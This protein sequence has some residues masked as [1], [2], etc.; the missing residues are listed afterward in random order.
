MTRSMFKRLQKVLIEPPDF[1]QDITVRHNSRLLNL[2]LLIMIIVFLGVDGY[3]FSTIPG[4]MPPWYGYVF[5]LGSFSLNRGGYY[6]FSALL[7]LAMFP[8]VIFANITSGESASPITTIYFLIPGLILAGIL[9]TFQF[10]A[11]FALTELLLVGSMPILAPAVIPNFE[12][13]VGPL[14]ALT[15]SGALVLVAIFHRDRMEADRQK[16]LQKSEEDY[17]AI[18]ENAIFGIYQSS[19]EGKFLRANSALARIYGYDSQQDLLDSVTSIAEQVYVDPSDRD[20]FRHGLVTDEFVS[21]FVARNRRKDGSLIWISSNARAV[22]NA[23]GKIIYFE[24]TVEDITEKKVM[25]QERQMSEERYRLISSVISDYVFSSRQTDKGEVQLEWVTGAFEQITGYAAEELSAPSSW[26]S[27]VHPDDLAQDSRDM[28]ALLHNQR[29]VSELRIIHKDGSIRWVRSYAHPIW[30]SNA[31]KLIGIYGAVQDIT[32]QKRFEQEREDLIRELE[33]KNA[34]LE[35]FTYTVSHDLKAPLITIRGF[36]GFLSQD[37][38]SGNVER[39]EGDLKRISAATDKMQNLLNDLLELSR[40]GRMMNDP[41][42][43]SLEQLAVDASELLHGRLKERGAELEVKSPLPKVFGDQQR[44]LEV[45]QN[46]ID[47]AAKF[48]IGQERPRVEIGQSASEREGFATLYVRDNGIG[49]APQFHER[50]FGLFNRLNPSIEGTGVGLPLVK[51]IVEF[52]GGRIWVESAEGKGA[53]FF[54]TLP[55]PELIK[56]DRPPQSG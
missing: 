24:G 47:N 50:I 18:V 40:I 35:Q 36:L 16:Q 46:L 38:H 11:L 19:P 49:I 6:R 14:A 52:H 22:K 21:G 55:S 48:T 45:F 2:F 17:R 32:E 51:R 7:T 54:F 56:E 10:T 20:R 34:E 43:I 41:V 39:L 30:D 5:L 12:T 25:E 29:V 28:D 26:R 31:N 53:T 42:E 13:V 1:I 33:L 4:Y 3:Y 27:I 9:L 23:S 15:I 8:L 44:L 37:A